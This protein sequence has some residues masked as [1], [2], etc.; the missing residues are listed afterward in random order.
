MEAVKSKKLI[1]KCF[2]CHAFATYKS[3]CMD[4]SCCEVAHADQIDV[5]PA[6]LLIIITAASHLE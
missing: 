2:Q 6:N 4:I 5:K 3:N 1:I